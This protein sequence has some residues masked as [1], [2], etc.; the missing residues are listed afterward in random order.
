M[1]HALE[2]NSR[3]G[4]RLIGDEIVAF[5]CKNQKIIIWNEVA[6]KLWKMIAEGKSIEHLVYWLINEYSIEKQQAERDILVFLQEAAA[7]EL[8]NVDHLRFK[9]VTQDVVSDGENVLLAVEM[10][11]IK[12][13]IP[14]AIT[15]EITYG[16]NERCIHCYME[17]NSL[18]LKLSEVKRILEEVAE[19]GCL[20]VSFTGGEFFVYSEALKILEYANKLHFVID[21]LSNGTLINQDI[22][23]VLAEYSV[24][25][26]Q[27]SLYGATPKIHDAITRVPGSF[28]ATIA[29]VDFLKKAG[30]KVEIAFP[31]MQQNFHE[32]YVV[33]QL[34]ESMDCA[35]SPSPIITAR[36]NGS[37]DTFPLRLSDEQVQA[38]L[39]DRGLSELY[40][41]RR[42][43]QDHQHYLGSSDLLEFAPC[44]SGFNTCAITPAGK[45][46]PCNQLLYEVGD[47][48]T[49]S[50]SEIWRDSSQ[51]HHIR[52]LKVRDLEKCVSCESFFF[53]ARCPGLALLEGGD[54]LGP[55][56]E[57]CR[58]ASMV[59]KLEA[60]GGEKR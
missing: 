48:K 42:P 11:A 18:S 17:K 10:M 3:V 23:D 26:V 28:L 44:Y 16:C 37:R 33:K 2:I 58:I 6:S 25:R 9:S 46:L 45:V 53:C 31:L 57:N 32:R 55:A 49:N 59:Q 14:F 43:F 60:K 20:F 47:L 7:I 51:L 13:L 1:K 27:I 35:L 29:G 54:I 19:E 4:W 52:S 5:N 41:G 22:A 8:I 34:I 15:F 12:H 40:A 30:V 38:F 56:L 36:N 24:R 21:I 50:F 39:E